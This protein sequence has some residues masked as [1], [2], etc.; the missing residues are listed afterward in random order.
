MYMKYFTYT[1]V[2]KCKDNIT[3][4]TANMANNTHSSNLPIWYQQ[5]VCLCK[6]L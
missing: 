1:L 5:N 3:V 4:I 6:M 2:N